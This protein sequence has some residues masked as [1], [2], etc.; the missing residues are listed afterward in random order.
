[1][2]QFVLRTLIFNAIYMYNVYIYTSCCWVETLP[3]H[4]P[5][6]L[7]QQM[8]FLNA[9]IVSVVQSFWKV[10]LQVGFEVLLC[11]LTLKD[12]T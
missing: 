8:N 2:V 12:K 4:V 5:L 9:S 3:G 11:F 1:M 7:H 6:P 10:L